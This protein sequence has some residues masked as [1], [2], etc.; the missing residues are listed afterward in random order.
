M[1]KN[2]QEKT[3]GAANALNNEEKKRLGTLLKSFREERHLN[4]EE[5][6]G[7]IG[8]TGQYVSDVERGKYSL[9]LKKY[10]TICD[11]FGVSADELIYGKHG[12]Y[13]EFDVRNRIIRQI[14]D[15]NIDQIDLLEDQI[16]LMKK[17]FL[18]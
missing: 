10:M 4:Q 11:H 5:F 18:V 1:G 9:S 6:A 16:K 7:I 3:E 2:I 14:D 17:M 13:S 15:M 8:C 12:T